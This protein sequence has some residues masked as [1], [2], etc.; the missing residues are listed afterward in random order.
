MSISSPSDIVLGVANAADPQKYQAAVERLG[1]AAGKGLAAKDSAPATVIDSGAAAR[2]AKTGLYAR[3][4]L[5]S[6]TGQTKPTAAATAPNKTDQKTY[7]DFEAF[8]LQTFVESILPKNAESLFGG[9]PAGKIWKS[10]LAEHLA[11]ELARSTAF[12]IA[13]KIAENRQEKKAGLTPSAGQ[14]PDGASS[15]E[16][17]KAGYLSDLQKLLSTDDKTS[18][19]PS[20]G[21]LQPSPVVRG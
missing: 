19:L 16:G 20:N 7:E 12:G 11:N 5:T 8:F 18:G 21:R 15:A 1:R 17:A 14:A 13:E 6:S 3:S 2:S 4:P 9:G 10:M